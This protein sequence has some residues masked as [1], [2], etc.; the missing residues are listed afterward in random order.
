S[1]ASSAA[2]SSPPPL[3][4]TSPSTLSSD[5]ARARAAPEAG[6]RAPRNTTRGPSRDNSHWGRAGAADMG[7]GADA[8]AAVVWGAAAA[9]RAKVT[10]AM[11]DT[12][13]PAPSSLRDRH[14]APAARP[15]SKT[16]LSTPP[17]RDDRGMT[18][19]SDHAAKGLAAPSACA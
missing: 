3:S 9:I 15:M 17:N 8:G 10:A 6:F 1:A 16:I 11:N 19:P 7:V 18:A 4:I 13:P 14:H 5:R 2:F 12:G